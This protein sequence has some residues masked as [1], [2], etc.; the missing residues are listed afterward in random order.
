MGFI[1]QPNLQKRSHYVE[2]HMR[3]ALAPILFEE[4]DND[5]IDPSNL[6]QYEPSSEVKRKTGSRRTSDGLPVHSFS[7][8]LSDL[9]TI[10]LNKISIS[11]L[12][13]DFL[14]CVL[15]QTV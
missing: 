2:W 10:N 9:A 14:F 11:I 15:M 13:N 3:E 5:L 6:F 8:L 7:T 12:S 4:V 1:L